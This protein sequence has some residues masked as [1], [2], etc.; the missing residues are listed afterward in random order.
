MVKCV[1]VQWGIC[2]FE[3]SQRV[4]FLWFF[5][6][7]GVIMQETKLVVRVALCSA[8]EDFHISMKNSGPAFAGTGVLVCG[9]S[10]S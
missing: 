9:Q 4:Q 10:I 2:G 8:G 3:F 5:N 7:G 1:P 6:K